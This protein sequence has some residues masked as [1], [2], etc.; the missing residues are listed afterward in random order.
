MAHSLERR[1][2]ARGQ[3]S[4]KLA[5]TVGGA[6]Y[7]VG[8]LDEVIGAVRETRNAADQPLEA[9]QA[10]EAAAADPQRRIE[11]GRRTFIGSPPAGCCRRPHMLPAVSRA[12]MTE[13]VS[14]LS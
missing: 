2:S 9:S 14:K 5:S 11:D 4:A 7:M 3:I 1:N 8:M 13:A 12:K 6:K 10:A